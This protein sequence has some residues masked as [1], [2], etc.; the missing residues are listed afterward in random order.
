MRGLHAAEG[1]VG[2][3][4]NVSQPE[5]SPLGSIG[6]PTV[7]ERSFSNTIMSPSAWSGARREV[8]RESVRGCGDIPS[9]QQI[10]L[11]RIGRSIP[12]CMRARPL[13]THLSR[14]DES[15]SPF[16]PFVRH[17]ATSL[18]WLASVYA[19]TEHRRDDDQLQHGREPS[20]FSRGP[21]F[22]LLYQSSNPSKSFSILSPE[23]RGRDLLHL[24]PE[25]IPERIWP[26]E[27]CRQNAVA[28]C[29]ASACTMAWSVKSTKSIRMNGPSASLQLPISTATTLQPP[30]TQTQGAPEDVS[31]SAWACQ[32]SNR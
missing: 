9:D 24:S 21:S 20:T 27:G 25:L 18:G 6:R 14:Y 4:S 7:A 1:A 19:C 8:E 16:T 26:W 2:I 17:A 10:A 12:K 30:H 5:E 3:T 13:A 23:M 22:T 29:E 11:R 15:S 28:E 31:A 32:F